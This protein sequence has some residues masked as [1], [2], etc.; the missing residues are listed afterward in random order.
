MINLSTADISDAASAQK[1]PEAVKRRW[2]WLKHLFADSAHDRAMLMDKAALLDFAVEVVRKK[3]DQHT[4]EPLQRRW[5]VERSFGWM[6]KW[7]R[8]V[9][10]YEQRID[11]SEQ[12]ICVAASSL[13]LKRLCDKN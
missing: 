9:R 10:A 8:L 5:V 2:P 7:R 6:M 1:V 12:M 3:N 13:L 11:V 4:F